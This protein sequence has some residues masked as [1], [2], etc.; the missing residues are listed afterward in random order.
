M[1]TRSVL[2]NLRKYFKTD[3]WSL[4]SFC[5]LYQNESRSISRKKKLSFESDARI[6]HTSSRRPTVQSG[7]ASTFLSAS[8]VD[9][10][11]CRLQ[12][13]IN[14]SLAPLSS[15]N[16]KFWSSCMSSK[17]H[18]RKKSRQVIFEFWALDTI[19][20]STLIAFFQVFAP[21]LR[22]IRPNS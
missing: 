12:E 19:V 6:C 16:W 22:Y 14:L 15:T 13:V 21:I 17:Q 18:R 10:L 2:I 9:S 3:G 7:S 1:L 4:T 11:E 8:K 5:P 20:M